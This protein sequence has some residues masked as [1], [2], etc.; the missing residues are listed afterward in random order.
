LKR[1]L[2]LIG[3]L[4]FM[5]GL[6][7]LVARPSREPPAATPYDGIRGA[8][9][10]KSSGLGISVRRGPDVSALAPGTPVH[11]GDVLHFRARVDRPRHLLVRLRDGAAPAGTIF[12]TANASASV[13]VQPGQDLQIAPVLGPGTGKVIVTA[14]FA[15]HPFTLDG[16]R[17]AD[18]EQI[19]LVMEKEARAAGE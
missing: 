16:A 10:A 13:L 1:T 19:D 3:A 8:S 6:A 9:R 5:L 17:G 4:A 12:P 7:F 15:D 14:I 11:A 2:I 18:S